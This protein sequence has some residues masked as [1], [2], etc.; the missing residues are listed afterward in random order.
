MSFFAGGAEIFFIEA[1]VS[2]LLFSLLNFIAGSTN[3][4]AGLISDTTQDILDDIDNQTG[5]IADIINISS[6]DVINAVNSNTDAAITTSTDSINSILNDLADSDR[7]LAQTVNNID[8][9]FQ[10]FGGDI[11]AGIGDLIFGLTDALNIHVDNQIDIDASLIDSVSGQIA[12]VAEAAIVS[13]NEQRNVLA[14]LFDVAIGAVIAEVS[15]GASVAERVGIDIVEAIL[16]NSQAARDIGAVIEKASNDA[17]NGDFWGEIIRAAGNGASVTAE[18][19]ASVY[20]NITSADFASVGVLCSPM[21]EDG[22]WVPDNS[23]VNAIVNGIMLALQAVMVPLALAQQRGQLCLQADSLSIPWNL[24]QPGDANE[25]LRRGII[26]K[27]TAVDQIRRGGWSQDQAEIL[28]NSA[29]TIPPLE[30]LLAQWFRGIIDEDGI[31][32]ELK[33]QG[34]TDPRIEAIKEVSYFLPPVQDLV[35]MAVREVFSPEKAQANGQFDEFPPDFEFWAEKQGL[36][37]DWAQKYWAAHWVLPSP[38]MGF[39]MFQRGVIT[40]QRLKDLM[41]ALDIMPRWRDELIKISYNPITRVDIR[42][43]HQLLDKDRE[44]LIRRY[45][46]VGYSPDD[47]AELAEFTEELNNEESLLSLDVASDLTRSNIVTFYKRGVI[48]YEIALGLL[49]QANINVAAAAL[50]LQNADLE[51]ELR[52]RQDQVDIV[53]ER[54]KVGEKTVTDTANAIGALDLEPREREAALLE[55]EKMRLAKVKEPTRANLDAF[56]KAGIIDK[57]EYME[58]M[59]RLGYDSVWAG[60]FAELT[61]GAGV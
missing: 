9:G 27:D 8:Q 25:A 20:R 1:L 16:T 49:L 17:A 56:G 12:D 28:I 5:V 40:E 35:T 60:R 4:T 44:W 2:N 33:S 55:L 24:L 41:A 42:R 57:S 59:H 61:F 54:Y 6:E 23:W 22:Q 15:Q 13:V 26:D 31:N 36:T 53:L 30:I 47:A 29:D 38:Q 10:S 14:D 51:L 34:F 58:E 32:L 39:E 19:L 50:F 7:R 37:K 21:P 45:Q 48:S 43:I 46:D 3:I 18:Q 52:E 11:V